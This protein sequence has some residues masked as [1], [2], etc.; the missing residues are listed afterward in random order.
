MVLLGA[1][2]TVVLAG[3]GGKDPVGP[4]V[5]GMSLPDAEKA[6]DSAKIGYSEHASDAAFGI[7]VKENF[8]VCKEAYVNEQMVRL[9]V[10]KHGC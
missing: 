9:E 3:C 4:D 6:L 1:L 5:R 10:A 8:V 2:A 7:I